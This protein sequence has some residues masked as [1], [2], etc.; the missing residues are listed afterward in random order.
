MREDMGMGISL[1]CIAV[2]CSGFPRVMA[3][4]TGPSSV[5][6]GLVPATHDFPFTTHRKSWVA[7]PSPAMTQ[8]PGPAMTK[9]PNLAMTRGLPS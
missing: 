3:M 2:T 1:S 6:V 5:M 7:G 9:R 4:R 8:I